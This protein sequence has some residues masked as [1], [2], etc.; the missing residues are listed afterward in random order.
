MDQN[1]RAGHLDVHSYFLV[2]IF[3]IQASKEDDSAGKALF[4]AACQPIRDF[5]S[6]NRLE[7][8]V[9]YSFGAPNFEDFRAGDGSL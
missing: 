8:D 5:V 6:V 2:G 1:Y 9:E 4:L 7:R 3:L